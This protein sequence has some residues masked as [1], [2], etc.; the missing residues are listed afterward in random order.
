MRRH[1]NDHNARPVESISDGICDPYRFRQPGRWEINRV[2]PRRNHRFDQIWFVCPK[3]NIARLTSH[4]DGQRRSPSSGADNRDRKT[5]NG[6]S[7][8]FSYTA[9]EG[10]RVLLKRKTRSTENE[11]NSCSAYS[12]A[13]VTSSES[14]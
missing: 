8:S 6:Y 7:F 3:A 5:H 11:P 2:L 14:M 4:R 13:A 1:R 12:A 10:F 9:P